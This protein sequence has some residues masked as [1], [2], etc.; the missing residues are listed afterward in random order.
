M[1]IEMNNYEDMVFLGFL[2]EPMPQ[3]C[4]NSAELTKA[5][6]EGKDQGIAQGIITKH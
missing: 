2:G 6:N 4:Y 3:E 1:I 5:F